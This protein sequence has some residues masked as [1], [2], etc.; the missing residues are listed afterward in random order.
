MEQR[1]DYSVPSF[2]WSVHSCHW[3]RRW[4][5]VIGVVEGARG[6][7]CASLRNVN[8]RALQTFRHLSL[9]YTQTAPLPRAITPFGGIKSCIIGIFVMAY[10]PLGCSSRLQYGTVVAKIFPQSPIIFTEKRKSGAQCGHVD[11]IV[12][13]GKYLVR[14]PDDSPGSRFPISKFC[15]KSILGLRS[16]SHKLQ[17]SRSGDKGRRIDS[18]PWKRLR[19]GRSLTS[20]WS[21]TRSEPSLGISAGSPNGR[22]EFPEGGI[23]LD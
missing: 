6:A 7:H 1:T 20:T 16:E 10:V 13:T 12:S 2:C 21:T 22:K 5:C 8:V 15:E 18:F 11:I 9:L 4:P 23:S 3:R 14:R 17:Y 19:L